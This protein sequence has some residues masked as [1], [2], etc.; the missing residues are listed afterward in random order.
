MSYSD[1]VAVFKK[2]FLELGLS[3]ANYESFNA[4]GLNTLGTFAFSCNFA[5]G[6]A[7]ERPLV[8]LATNVLGTAPTTRQMA[9]IRRLFSE[10]YST[11][12]ADIRSKVEATDDTVVKRLAPA[13]RSQRLR[14]QQA[15]LS[16]LDLRGNFE[17]GDSL[18][19]KAVACYESDRLS[20]ISWDACVSRDHEIL[21]GSKRD[22]SLTFDTS[23]S[24]K[25]TKRDQVEPC[26]A[27]N[28]IQVRYCL[29]RRGL[30]L[31]Q[32]N[33]LCYKLHDRLAEKLMNIRMEEPPAGC[34]RVSLKQIETADKKFWT[35]LSEKT[36]DGIKSGADGRPCDKQFDA[37]FNS[38]E[39]LN[40]LQHRFGPSNSSAALKTNDQEEP[41]LKKVKTVP[42]KGAGKASSFMRIPNDLLA[43]GCVGQTSKGHRL[44]FDFNLKKCKLHVKDQR[45]SK[46]LHLCGVKGCHKNHPAL[47]CPNKG[48]GGE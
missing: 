45:C 33:I 21:T 3:E 7:D 34:M 2:R 25:L 5:P 31:D 22:T 46:G 28:E 41:K 29:I 30:A 11:I 37:C 19:D 9:C 8:T 1:S 16:G 32:G 24:L 13:E 38:P 36:R 23:G 20:Y 40:L 10:A 44:C 47:D 6:S 43:V 27:S 14:D 15:R 18:V 42:P 12:A 26:N 39:F 4:E 17:P 48:S 35:L